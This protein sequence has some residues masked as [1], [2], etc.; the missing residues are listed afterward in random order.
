MDVTAKDGSLGGG[1]AA[2]KRPHSK[3]FAW[4]GALVQGQTKGGRGKA[5]AFAKATAR[6]GVANR[7]PKSRQADRSF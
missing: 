7:S 5:S 6:Q 2:L 1:E 4:A 3:R